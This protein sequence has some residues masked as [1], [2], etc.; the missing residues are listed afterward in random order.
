MTSA[1]DAPVPRYPDLL[2]LEGRGFMVLGAGQGIGRQT[3][4]ALAQAGARV[5]CVDNQEQLAK[6]IADEV[7]GVAW[8]ADARE[9]AEV[10]EAVAEARREFG[11]VDGLIDIVGM[12]KYGPLL[13]T[14]DEDWEWSFGM[15]L[16]HAFL[17]TQ[18]AGRA[19]GDSGG[20]VLV[21]VA[22]V[23]GLT[24]APQHAAY[25]AA[26]AGLISLIRSA[27]VELGSRGVRVNGVAPGVVWTPR[28][29]GI[30]GER[31]RELQANNA[32]L[33]R[34]AETSDI[35]SAILFLAS[36]LSSYVSGQVV[37]V[38]GG[39]S[40]KFPYPMEM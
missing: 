25:G 10:D 34:V 4:H 36:D 5:F 37:V 31:G 39:V 22:S 13:D 19:M 26:K 18:A 14:T 12:A 27:A 21:F 11:K 33:G 35:A 1:D 6:Q 3:S 32:P 16:R 8:A 29:S 24:S 30:L 23:S 2:G 38:D 7:D 15:V 20:G 40:A 9:R 28:V 17:A